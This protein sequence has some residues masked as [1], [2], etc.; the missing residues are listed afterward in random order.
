M[1]IVHESHTFWQIFYLEH[2]RFWD[3]SLKY[4]HHNFLI[5]SIFKFFKGLP[6]KKCH[7]HPSSCEK[8]VNS[9]I[10]WL[11]LLYTRLNAVGQNAY[12]LNANQISPPE[13]W[14]DNV[15]LPVGWNMLNCK[16]PEPKINQDPTAGLIT[17]GEMRTKNHTRTIL[18]LDLGAFLNSV[19]Q[20][21]ALSTTIW[22]LS[23]RQSG[24]H[25]TNVIKHLLLNALSTTIWMQSI[26]KLAMYV[27]NVIKNW[28]QNEISNV[29]EH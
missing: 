28:I 21:N 12:R 18:Y 17:K 3:T 2:F 29:K 20:L 25:V 24:M 14:K 10:W 23:I 5:N 11:G 27:K 26:R 6:F 1:L 8:K 13:G 19:Y 22:V 15:Y 4:P 7:F 16:F 9:I